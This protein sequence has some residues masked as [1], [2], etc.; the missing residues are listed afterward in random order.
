MMPRMHR[1]LRREEG[2][3][4]QGNT[5]YIVVIALIAIASIAVVSFFSQNL[6]AI[7]AASDNSLGGAEKSSIK[8]AG[9]LSPGGAAINKVTR[10]GLQNFGSNHH[11]G[12]GAG[13]WE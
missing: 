9:S 5:E 4:G 8:M 7:F 1:L 10:K 6:R 11:M 2:Q 3:D 13:G 12:G